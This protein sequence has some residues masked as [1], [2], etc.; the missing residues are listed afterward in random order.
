MSIPVILGK[1][2]DGISLSNEEFNEISM[3]LV[4]GS[5]SDAQSAAFA[6]GGTNPGNA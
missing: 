3:G 1:V 2:R 4:D 5:V 6:M